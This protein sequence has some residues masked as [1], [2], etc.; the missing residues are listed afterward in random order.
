MLFANKVCS[1]LCA[2]ALI[3]VFGGGVADAGLSTNCV[4][5]AG[6][7][8][9]LLVQIKDKSK[10]KKNGHDQSQNDT[11]LTDCTIVS[12]GGGGGCKSG[13]NYVCEKL[14]SGKKCCG[15]V[16][17]KSKGTSAGQSAPTGGGG[18]TGSGGIK[19]IEEVPADTLLLPYCELKGEEMVCTPQQ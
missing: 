9:S 13:F 5:A 17:D 7:T 16:A 8:T 6:G 19:P 15:C 2:V 14:K 1:F 10:K 11:G 12:P 3:L 18:K 4:A